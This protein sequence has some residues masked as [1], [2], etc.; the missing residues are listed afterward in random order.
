[1]NLLIMSGRAIV[2]STRSGSSCSTT[3]NS[4]LKISEVTQADDGEYICVAVYLVPSESI[5][6]PINILG[7]SA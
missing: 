3:L 1:M 6:I 4:T 2:N 7:K 5:Q